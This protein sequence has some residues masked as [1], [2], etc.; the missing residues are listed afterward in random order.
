VTGR[1]KTAVEHHDLRHLEVDGESIEFTSATVT[2]ETIWIEAD[3][4]WSKSTPSWHGQIV[5]GS[6]R[7]D[8]IETGLVH[9]LL[10]ETLSGRTL[11]GY[12]LISRPGARGVDITGSGTLTL[13]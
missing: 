8:L 12:F 9:M 4:Q 5:S 3:S 1:R 13:S 7:P 2:Q 6:Y 10:G 11:S